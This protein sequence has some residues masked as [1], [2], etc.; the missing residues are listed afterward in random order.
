MGIELDVSHDDKRGTESKLARPPDTKN[1][2]ENK[3]L[4]LKITLLAT[5]ILDYSMLHTLCCVLDAVWR[6]R[7]RKCRKE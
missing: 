2:K 1:Y 7:G 4:E 5:Y 3:V 6:P